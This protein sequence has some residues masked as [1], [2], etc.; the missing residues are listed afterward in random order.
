MSNRASSKSKPRKNWLTANDA[1]PTIPKPPSIAADYRYHPY[2]TPEY[3][4]IARNRKLIS[5]NENSVQL[6]HNGASDAPSINDLSLSSQINNPTLPLASPSS[7]FLPTSSQR[8][9]LS[10]IHNLTPH[11]TMQTPS[12]PQASSSSTPHP[13]NSS[14]LLSSLPPL[15]PPLRKQKRTADERFIDDLEK[16]DNFLQ[17][18]SAEFGCLGNFLL[19]VFWSRE[20]KRDEDLRSPFHKKA[21]AKFLSGRSSINIAH[22]TNAIFNHRN[23]YPSWRSPRKHERDLDFSLIHE[24]TQIGFAR[25]SL[26]TWAAQLCARQAHRDV[27]LLTKNDPEHPEYI[28]AV[29]PSGNVTWDDILN[30]SP[31]RTADTFKQRTPFLYS[32]FKY[33]AAPRKDGKAVQRVNRPNEMRII[34]SLNP[35]IVGHNRNVNGY[36]S[37][38]M[39]IHLFASQVHRDVKRSLSQMGLSSHESTA[40]RSILTMISK[41]RDKMQEQSLDAAEQGTV[42][43]CYI[44]DNC[45]RYSDVYEGGVLRKSKMKIG[46]AGTAVDLKNCSDDAWNLQDHLTRVMN[47]RRSTM[48]VDCLWTSINWSHHHDSMS[49]L[50]VK[51]LADEVAALRSHSKTVSERFRESPMA[52]HCL[53]DDYR[54]SIQPLGTNAENELE[55]QGMARIMTDFDAQIGYPEESAET[56]IEWVGGDGATFASIERVKKFLAPTALSNRLTFRNKIA[57]PE[58]WHAKYTAIKAISETHFGPSSSSDPSSLSKLF[59]CVGLK[60]PANPKQVDHYPMVH[61]FKLVW[62]AQ[63][64]DCWRVLFNTDDLEKYFAH[65]NDKGNLPSFEI[66]LAHADTL[67]RQYMCSA[68]YERVL[69]TKRQSSLKNPILKVK[70]GTPWV[71]PNVLPSQEQSAQTMETKLKTDVADFDGDRSLANSIA[72][73]MQFGSWLLLDHAIKGG[74]IGQVM[75]QFKIWIFMFAGEGLGNLLGLKDSRT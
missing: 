16:V 4:R 10:P 30:F 63:I 34:A 44:V 64:L 55:T 59:S 53:P 41:A 43:K 33:L 19:L 27:S 74:D 36:L 6:A 49:L 40:R 21:V 68:A 51:T 72:F 48:T 13:S 56:T 23:S 14:A 35:L 54:T 67:V 45:Q 2:P 46:S 66:L 25:C 26:R 1:T 70:T 37:L 61:G 50:L 58:A 31:A 39:S 24:P 75:E 69:S 71:S 47:N 65:L 22:I 20:H 9:P 29:L 28:P 8:V 11:T 60:R 32:F 12:T 42:A 5:S 57:T 52:I 62:T 18:I 15:Q 73:K 3:L 38:P 7:I 17:Q